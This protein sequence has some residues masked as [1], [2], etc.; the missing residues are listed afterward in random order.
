MLLLGHS[1]AGHRLSGALLLW[2]H[3][4]LS[5]GTGLGPASEGV[6]ELPDISKPRRYDSEVS[7]SG[8]CLPRMLVYSLGVRAERLQVN[9]CADEHLLAAVLP[10]PGEPPCSRH[11]V[12]VWSVVPCSAGLEYIS[13]CSG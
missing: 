7:D 8:C 9:L 1:R 6:C 2:S 12:R 11:G 3:Q 5:A 4:R 10:R 13:L